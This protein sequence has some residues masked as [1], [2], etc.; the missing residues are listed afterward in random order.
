MIHISGEIIRNLGVHLDDKLTM[1]THVTK[2]I[3]SC[4]FQLKSIASIRPMLDIEVTKLLVSSLILSRID[5]CNAL[6]YGCPKHTTGR[7]QKIQNK[8]ARLVTL[9]NQGIILLQ[10]FTTFIGYL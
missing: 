1:N 10:H 4:N 3:Q 2:T 5:Y 7:L 6:L 8:A 9:K